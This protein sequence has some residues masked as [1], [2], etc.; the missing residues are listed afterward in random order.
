MTV[1]FPGAQVRLAPGVMGAD[2]AGVPE[3]M[4]GEETAAMGILDACGGEALVCFPGTHSKW[5]QIVDRRITRFTTFMTGEMYSAV[6]QSTILG[7]M[8]TSEAA[9]DNPAFLAGVTRAGQAGGLLHHL[10]G[11]RTLGLM[12]RLR[13]EDSASYLS[14]VADRARRAGHDEAGGSCSPGWHGGVVRPLCGSHPCLRR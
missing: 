10:F 5:L 7:R 4:R 9:A 3:V 12:G 8:M 11:V 13:E 6:R 14:G 1:P 2:A